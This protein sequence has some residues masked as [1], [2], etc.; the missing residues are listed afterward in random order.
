MSVQEPVRCLS[1]A[2]DTWTAMH[3]I[4]DAD[5][6]QPFSRRLVGGSYSQVWITGR[7]RNG[8]VVRLRGRGVGKHCAESH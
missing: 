7:D 6:F 8:S 4:R 5:P 1:H 3:R 2:P